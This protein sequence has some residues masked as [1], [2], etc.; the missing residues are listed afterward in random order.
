MTVLH[1]APT[2]RMRLRDLTFDLS[3]RSFF[4]TNSAQA[5]R[6]VDAVEAA[7]GFEDA[8]AKKSSSTCS[9][10]RARSA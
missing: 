10:A 3:P 9:A 7:C 5:E 1:G 8:K 4:Q 6:L 2:L